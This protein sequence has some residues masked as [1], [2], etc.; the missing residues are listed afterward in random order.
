MNAR[1]AVLAQWRAVRGQ[2][3]AFG[4]DDCLCFAAACAQAITGRDPIAHLRGRYDSEISARRLMV[5][6]GWSDMGDVA[7]SI[8]PEVPFA[9]ARSGDWAHVMQAD[10]T[11]GLGVVVGELIAVRTITGAAQLRLA[12]A[13]R[14]F[15][16]A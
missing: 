9:Q 16:V 5:E 4:T 15:R 8:F 1:N 3:G 12:D 6:N 13:K 11:D 10:G 2:P 7:A 14:V